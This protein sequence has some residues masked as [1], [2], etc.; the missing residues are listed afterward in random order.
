MWIIKELKMNMIR[1]FSLLAVAMLGLMACTDESSYTYGVWYERSDMDGKP[2]YA[3][4]AFTIG[5]KGYVCSGYTTGTSGH[6]RD[7][8]MYDI[9]GDYW[10][11]RASMP[12]EAPT[13]SAGVGFAVNGKGYITTGYSKTNDAVTLLADTWEYNPTANS[14]TQKDDFGGSGRH[15]ALAFA[16]G[17][18]GYVGTG[19][20]DDEGVLKDF[21][22]FDPDAAPGSQWRVVNGFGGN[23]RRG[24]TVFVIKDI[25]YICTG[26]N[27][28]Y[29]YDMWKFDPSKSESEQWT[30]LRDIK[31]SSDESYDD[32]YTTI[33]RG[34][35]VSFVID[36]RGYLLTG[37]VSGSNR[38]DYWV[39]DPDTDLWNNED[40]TP[41]EG[42]NRTQAV[43]FSTGTRG[44]VTTGKSGSYYLDDTWELLPYE[45]EED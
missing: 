7:L 11:Q 8:W 37:D 13:R 14:W 12:D 45:L 33:V 4:A 20:N 24:G 9:D 19:Q 25:A 42:T 38:S 40:F 15:E 27:N 30:K 36:N 29:V 23:K 17:N 34:F 32:D 10:T 26:Q 3:A 41:F 16:I 1:C 39:Y 21:Y 5:N 31:D 6:L 43:G 2:R 22:R 44:F 18:Y 28:G 35:A